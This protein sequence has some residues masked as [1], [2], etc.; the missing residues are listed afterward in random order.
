MVYT[1]MSIDKRQ[2]LLA[3][4]LLLIASFIINL[5]FSALSPVFPYLILA[6]KGVLKE[7]PELAKDMIQA[8]KGA[9][10]LGMLTAAFMVTRAPTAGIVGFLSDVLGK[11]R[12]ILLG[13]GVYFVSS[14]GFVLSNDL[15]L[16]IVFRGLQGIASAMVWLVAEAYLVDITPRWSRGKTISIYTSSMLVAEI[17]GPSIG[18]GVY[19]LYVTFFGSSNI[20]LALKSPIVFLALSCFFS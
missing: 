17:L 15:L 2:Y 12:T 20:V 6:L 5:G 14:L 11:K 4:S 13:M 9:V 10:E 19:K 1:A 7:L 3:V 8:H 16:F 18:V